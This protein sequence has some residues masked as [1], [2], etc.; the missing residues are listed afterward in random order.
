MRKGSAT[1]VGLLQAGAIV[2]LACSLLAFAPAD[3]FARG[4]VQS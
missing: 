3:H 4:D 1:L 2:T